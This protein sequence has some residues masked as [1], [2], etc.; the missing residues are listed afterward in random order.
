MGWDQKTCIQTIDQVHVRPGDGWRERDRIIRWEVFKQWT[1]YILETDEEKGIRSEVYKQLTKFNVQAGGRGRGGGRDRMIR[2]EISNNWP[3]SRT[4]WW[5]AK[6]K[7][8]DDQMRDFQTIVH[9]HVH[10]GDGW[11]ERDGTIRW[12]AFKQLTKFTY[13]LDGWRGWLE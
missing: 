10:P 13:T 8:Y 12:E 9:I 4:N 3:C 6:R 5:R 2:W 1:T 11:R 7:G